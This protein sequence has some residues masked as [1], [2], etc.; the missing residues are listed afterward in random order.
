MTIHGYSHTNI[1]LFTKASSPFK[2]MSSIS[3]NPFK[4]VLTTATTFSPILRNMS[5]TYEYKIAL[6]KSQ[7]LCNVVTEHKSIQCTLGN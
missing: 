5:R 4:A 6:H 2:S 3:E 1:A 7:N